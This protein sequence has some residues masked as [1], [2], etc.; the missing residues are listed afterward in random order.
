MPSHLP[1]VETR[2]VP[3]QKVAKN[4]YYG[5]VIFEGQVVPDPTVNVCFV[6]TRF[7][8]S[9]IRPAG[10]RFVAAQPVMIRWAIGLP[11]QGRNFQYV[12]VGCHNLILQNVDCVSFVSRVGFR[13]EVWTDG[14]PVKVTGEVGLT[15][16][17]AKTKR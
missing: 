2:T 16:Y 11:I 5:A 17:T 9:L 1:T 6:E 15:I 14:D 8:S 10:Y 13:D 4:T 7:V 3:T 12:E